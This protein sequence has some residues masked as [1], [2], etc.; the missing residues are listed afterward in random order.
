LPLDR[1]TVLCPP[2]HL[3][4]LRTWVWGKCTVEITFKGFRYLLMDYWSVIRP[5]IPQV[6][7]SIA[8]M[9]SFP[10]GTSSSGSVPIQCNEGN[11]KVLLPAAN[12]PAQEG[13]QLSWRGHSVSSRDDDLAFHLRALRTWVWGKCTVEITFKGFRYLLMDYWSAIRP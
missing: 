1:S 13:Y 6:A 2:F 4:A 3:R 9:A 8:N 5:E 12:S 10:L 11:D 7:I